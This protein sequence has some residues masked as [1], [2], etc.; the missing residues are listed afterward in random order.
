MAANLQ[1]ARA[2][3]PGGETLRRYTEV[4]HL[5][6]GDFTATAEDGVHWVRALVAELQIPGLRVYGVAAEHVSILVERAA[7]ASS[8]KSNPLPLTAGELADIL[9]RSL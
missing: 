6:T 9:G 8:M 7:Q 2:R 3:L 1:A 4:A 5:L